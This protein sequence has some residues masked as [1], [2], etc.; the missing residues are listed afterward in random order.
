MRRSGTEKRRIR[1]GAGQN[2]NRDVSESDAPKV[3]F[4]PKGFFFIIIVVVVVV[5]VV[6]V[7]SVPFSDLWFFWGSFCLYSI[8]FL[9]R[10]T[11]WCPFFMLFSFVSC[12]CYFAT[13]VCYSKF[14]YFMCILWELTFADLLFVASKWT[15]DRLRGTCPVK[16]DNG[17]N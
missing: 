8:F 4:Q 11:D 14:R 2:R 6:V 17:A 5:V 7:I 16:F 12:L 1:R 3:S 9:I 15:R 13:S 10:I